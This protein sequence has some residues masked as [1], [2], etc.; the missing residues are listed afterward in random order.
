MPGFITPIEFDDE[1]VTKFFLVPT[2]GACVHTPPPPANQIVLVDYPQ[3]FPM[4]S[5]YTPVWVR[6]N[7]AI[8]KQK[9]DVTYV[10]GATNVE[11]VYSMTATS[12][13]LYE[14]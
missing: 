6:G 9:A 7:L 8:K 13:E 3:G 2:S 5:L 4:T 10:D 12:V 14:N 1:V 11:T